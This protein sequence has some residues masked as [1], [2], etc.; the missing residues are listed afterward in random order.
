[1]VLRLAGAPQLALIP[2]LQCNPPLCVCLFVFSCFWLFAFWASYPGS[3]PCLLK[4][5][6]VSHLHCFSLSVPFTAHRSTPTLCSPYLVFCFVLL[7]QRSVLPCLV[8]YCFLCVSF[9]SQLPVYSGVFFLCT[10]YAFIFF[11]FT[12]LVFFLLSQSE[13]T[14]WMPY[15]VSIYRLPRADPLVAL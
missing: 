8:L 2:V 13:S 3:F 9:T 7:F 4:T 12:S 5:F 11:F 6:L 15:A 10:F 14:I 1:M